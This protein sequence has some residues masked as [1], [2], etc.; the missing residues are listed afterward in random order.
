MLNVYTDLLLALKS[1]SVAPSTELIVYYEN[2][3]FNCLNY[4]LTPEEIEKVCKV[5]D[6]T[7]LNKTFWM[8][9]KLEVDYLLG[10]E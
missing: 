8:P 2:V 5:M 7:E 4:L 1:M 3:V 6:E 10:G 9:V